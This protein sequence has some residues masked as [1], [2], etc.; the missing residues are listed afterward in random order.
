MHQELLVK[1]TEEQQI[2]CLSGFVN[3]TLTE[4]FIL[5]ILNMYLNKIDINIDIKDN[6]TL[7]CAIENVKVTDIGK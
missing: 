5:N 1:A 3:E 2:Q 6:S 7:I 4:I